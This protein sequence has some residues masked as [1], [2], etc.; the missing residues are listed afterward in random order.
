MNYNFTEI[1]NFANMMKLNYIEETKDSI[2]L[3]QLADHNSKVFS[4]SYDDEFSRYHVIDVLESRTG[5]L[6]ADSYETHHEVLWFIIG[7]CKNTSASVNPHLYN[8]RVLTEMLSSYYTKINF[9]Y[10]SAFGEQVSWKCESD[11][12]PNLSLNYCPNTG[13]IFSPSEVCI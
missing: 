5:V 11:S 4:I 3:F 2:I 13:K 9:Y 12:L 6:R 10:H 1:V 7:Q 8:I